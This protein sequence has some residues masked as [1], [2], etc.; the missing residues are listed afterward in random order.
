[1]NLCLSKPENADEGVIYSLPC[2]F[3]AE[4]ERADGHFCVTREK[5]LVYF[6]GRLSGEYDINDFSEFVCRRQIGSSMAQGV[7]KEHV[8]L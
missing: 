2:S 1:M 5:I 4:G 8:L 6:G 3:T 7:T